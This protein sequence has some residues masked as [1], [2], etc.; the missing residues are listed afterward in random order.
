MPY[1]SSLAAL[2]ERF[3]LIG[4]GIAAQ[5]MEQNLLQAWAQLWVQ[6][7]L[8]ASSRG[9]PTSVPVSNTYPVGQ[10]VRGS[11]TWVPPA[12]VSNVE[13][14]AVYLSD[15][16]VGAGRV[17]MSDVILPSSTSYFYLS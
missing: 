6:L 8:F 7:G 15:S 12:G 4:I 2:L 11:A 14:Y 13:V 9:L 10:S 3:D 17:L 1:L 16:D 5:L